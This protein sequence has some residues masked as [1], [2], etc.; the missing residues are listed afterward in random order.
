MV[1]LFEICCRLGVGLALITGWLLLID[2]M[3]GAL[4]TLTDL[5]FSP[6]SRLGR[7]SEYALLLT[8]FAAAGAILLGGVVG[9][10]QAFDA[11]AT[12]TR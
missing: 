8:I 11:V 2:L 5:D 4:L 1:P 3:L 12:S 9:V 10:W 7:A 6:G